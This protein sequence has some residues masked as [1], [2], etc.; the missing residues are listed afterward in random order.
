MGTGEEKEKDIKGGRKEG[1]RAGRRESGG[2]RRTRHVGEKTVQE[3][4]MGEEL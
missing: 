4:T 3:T 1:N 2:R